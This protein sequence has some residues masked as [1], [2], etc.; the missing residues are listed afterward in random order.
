MLPCQQMPLGDAGI[1][2]VSSSCAVAG[3]SQLCTICLHWQPLEFMVNFTSVVLAMH[4]F[5]HGRVH[6]PVLAVPVI[7]LQLCLEMLGLLVQ[8]GL[9]ASSARHSWSLACLQG[10]LSP[11][12]MC[13]RDSQW[14]EVDVKQLVPGD[15]I[16]LKGGDVIPADA[17][18]SMPACVAAAT[19]RKA[20]V[21]SAGCLCPQCRARCCAP[22]MLTS[23]QHRT[24]RLVCLGYAVVIMRLPAGVACHNACTHRLCCASHRDTTPFL[25]AAGGAW[26]RDEN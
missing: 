2:G 6:V 11:N 8:R 13:C 20:F 7:V 4:A 17:N 1:C 18:V 14:S 5:L 24:C 16:Q 19:N 22:P 9:S 26:R 23:M 3:C 21:S 10:L 25:S 15:L 12:I